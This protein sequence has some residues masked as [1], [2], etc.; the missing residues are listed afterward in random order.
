MVAPPAASTHWRRVAPTG[1]RRVIG[2]RTAPATETNF[3]VTARRGAAATFMAV[4]T[5]MTTA[6]TWSGI[7]PGGI[8]RPSTS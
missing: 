2:R 4:S 8:T 7:P 5:F 1:T 3:S 6:P